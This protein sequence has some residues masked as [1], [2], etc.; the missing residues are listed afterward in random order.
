MTI[1]IV[2]ETGKDYADGYGYVLD[3]LLRDAGI[4]RQECLVTSVVPAA[5][6]YHQVVGPKTQGVPGLPFVER[7]KYLRAQYGKDLDRVREK[8]R[9]AAPTVIVAMNSLA[10]WAFTGLTSIRASRGFITPSD[11][12][13]VLPTYGPPTISAQ[14]NLRLIAVADLMK[15]RSESAFPELR[16]IKRNIWLRP[17]LE[18]LTT[19]L[20]DHILPNEYLSVD[21]ET[22]GN[23]ITCVGFA[24]TAH[25]ALVIPFYDPDRR[26]N[27]WPTHSEELSAWA[28][29]RQCLSLGKKVLYQNGLF[30]MSFFWQSVG[31]P[32]PDA[33]DD[34]MLLHHALQPE[35]Q[36]GLGFLASLYTNEVQWKYMG[37]A[38]VKKEG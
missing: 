1:A 27:Y 5:S 33:S 12:G 36:K 26:E 3:G 7:G 35:M 30:D 24:P 16:R 34:T 15:A 23:Q 32:N 11:Y 20:H 18:D 37:R 6:S 9:A 28:F 2:C 25:D 4:A 10:L 31:I 38:T 22:Q 17:S 8:V 19:F 13:K 21:I 14:W 29:I